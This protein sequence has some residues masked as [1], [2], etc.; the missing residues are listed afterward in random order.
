MSA[1]TKF[2]TRFYQQQKKKNAD[3]KFSQALK[4]AAKAYKKGGDVK[5]GGGGEPITLEAAAIDAINECTT[6][7][8]LDA[9]VAR[10]ADEL[11]ENAKVR[12]EAKK[13]SEYLDQAQKVVA[14]PD[15]KSDDASVATP[16][17]KQLDTPDDKQLDTPDST[18]G[19]KAK[20][21]AKKGKKSVKKGGKKGKKSA[22]KSRR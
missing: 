4:D 18:G 16:D 5:V 14:T 12:E 3:Y 22:K 20:K 15:D 19:K 21:S 6:K 11:Q 10:I 9:V 13:K 1:W 7:D 17:D 8:D 2:A